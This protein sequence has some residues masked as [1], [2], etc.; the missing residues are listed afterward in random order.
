[1]KKV[2]IIVVAI[3][4]ALLSLLS[5]LFI[6]TDDELLITTFKQSYSLVSKID[7]DD[8]LEVLIY[9][10]NKKASILNKNNIS[11]TYLLDEY[12]NQINLKID[13]ITY[14]D[15]E[16]KI[17]DNNY[18]LHSYVF[19]IDFNS[20]NEYSVYM[21]NAYLYVIV[22]DNTY[23]LEIGS[24]SY[25]KVLI[26]GDENNI[27]SIG[28]LTPV[29]NKI[30]INDTVLGLGLKIRN[31]SNKDIIIRNIEL[32]DYSLKSSMNEI[33]DI[34]I[35]NISS[36]NITELIGYSYNYKYDENIINNNVYIYI[37][38]NNEYMFLLPI[39]YTND[40]PINSFGFRIEYFL[41]DQN[42]TIYEYYFDDYVYFRSNY[43]T[44]K[45]KDIVINKYE[46]N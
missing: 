43:V 33:K 26:Y 15:Y 22:N 16:Q 8:K 28:Q 4:L 44:Y 30:D 46:N 6:K 27:I 25:T 5:L 24:F 3:C 41:N 37:E 20:N 34:N 18:Y 1:M 45:S 39:K 29:I 13:K 17:L 19:D 38:S 11:K 10:N 12:G 14:L 7:E 40:Y 21:K 35:N 42:N 32:L 2:I 36:M 23:K 31:L 9:I